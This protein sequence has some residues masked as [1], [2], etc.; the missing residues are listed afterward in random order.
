MLQLFVFTNSK[1][2]DLSS[3]S[4]LCVCACVHT[5]IE[6]DADSLKS[7]NNYSLN[8]LRL[9]FAT[10]FFLKVWFNN[11]SNTKLRLLVILIVS[12]LPFLHKHIKTQD[13][14]EALKSCSKLEFLHSITLISVRI[15]SHWEPN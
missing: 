1:D 10:F 12:V 6:K 8:D 14:D 5:D 3:G 9:L 11:G 2:Y 13:H 7:N 4:V 15:F